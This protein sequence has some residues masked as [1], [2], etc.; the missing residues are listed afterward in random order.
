M[1]PGNINITKVRHRPSD[2]VTKAEAQEIVHCSHTTMTK[3]IKE[4]EKLVGVRYRFPVTAEGISN[5]KLIDRLALNDYV[6]NRVKLRNNIPCAPYDPT[7]E[8]WGLGYYT[9]ELEWH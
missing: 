6:R 7:A 9:E 2:W 3:I 8:A 4:M 5:A 1:E